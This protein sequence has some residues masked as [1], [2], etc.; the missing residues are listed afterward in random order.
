[1]V[2]NSSVSST[3]KARRGRGDSRGAAARREVG[4]LQE[5]DKG[6][7]GG[8]VLAYRAGDMFRHGAALVAG[9]PGVP[10]DQAAAR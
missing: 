10:A 9:W 4:G 6:P 2:D 1:M 8:A 7:G 5:G 3:D